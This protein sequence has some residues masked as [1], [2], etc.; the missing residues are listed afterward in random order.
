MRIFIDHGL[1][2]LPDDMDS[3][4]SRAMLYAIA[5]QESG[6]QTRNQFGDGPARSFW[7]F[8]PIGVR[9]VIEHS[10]TSYFAKG[11]LGQLYIDE[12]AAY[13]A[14]AYS[15][16]LATAFARLNLWK[17]PDPLPD[18]GEVDKAWHQYKQIWRPGRPRPEKWPD[19][20]N[21]GWELALA[22]QRRLI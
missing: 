10:A 15:D 1:S 19:S 5:F 2:L 8:E 9:G 3:L 21:R 12:D 18:E 7:Q 17:F 13:D 4:E 6:F 20:F 11:V 22:E 14:I 16:A